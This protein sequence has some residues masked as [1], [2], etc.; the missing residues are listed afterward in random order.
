RARTRAAREG[1]WHQPEGRRRALS[2]LPGVPRSRSGRGGA[3]SAGRVPAAASPEARSRASRPAPRARRDPAGAR[4][5]AEVHAALEQR[6]QEEPRDM[7]TMRSRA[8][9]TPVRGAWAGL[10]SLTA[11]GAPALA[12][13]RAADAALRVV[14]LRTEYKENPVGIDTRKPRL[15]WRLDSAA[16]GVVQSAYEI[17]V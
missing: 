10:L 11:L 12:Q 13:P 9:F 17:R 15:S 16:R 1:D 4:C 8:G 3:E 7:S 5:R 6:K 2:A 14:G